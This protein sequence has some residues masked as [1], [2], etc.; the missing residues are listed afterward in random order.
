MELS[1]ADFDGDVSYQKATVN[2]STM[3]HDFHET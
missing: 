1:M 2:K 3:F